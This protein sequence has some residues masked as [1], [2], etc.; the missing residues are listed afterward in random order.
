MDQRTNTFTA[1]TTSHEQQDMSNSRN[2]D[3]FNRITESDFKDEEPDSLIIDA[4]DTE[5]IDVE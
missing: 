4:S 3:H 2:K 1:S 5:V